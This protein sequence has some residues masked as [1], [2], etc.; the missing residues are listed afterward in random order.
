MNEQTNLLMRMENK[1]YPIPPSIHKNTQ[2]LTNHTKPYHS[3]ILKEMSSKKSQQNQYS[4]NPATFNNPPSHNIDSINNTQ[5]S[6]PK[7]EPDTI[8]NNNQDNN[9]TQ[10][11][12]YQIDLNTPQ[13]NEL[14]GF[15]QQHMGSPQIQP[16]TE[17]EI[18]SESERESPKIIQY[19]N[20]G[21]TFKDAFI[22]RGDSLMSQNSKYSLNTFSNS[23]AETLKQRSDGF[24]APNEFTLNGNFANQRSPSFQPDFS[25][26]G[27]SPE[28]HL[29]EFLTPES[30]LRRQA[31]GQ[32]SKQRGNVKGSSEFIKSDEFFIE[33]K[34]IEGK[35]SNFSEHQENSQSESGVDISLE[36]TTESLN[37]GLHM[38]PDLGGRTSHF[39]NPNL[40]E[41]SGRF[42]FGYLC[43]C[44]VL[45]LL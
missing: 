22:P 16:E 25:G 20:S 9:K 41:I 23:H 36:C 35:G 43:Y 39:K 13:F 37:F 33:N 24:N 14:M 15:K 8:T 28:V 31:Q 38:S 44:L 17:R 42:F 2:S 30:A 40:S 21:I 34:V 12:E 10:E 4:T 11:D 1:H 18:T 6:E 3:N 26:S 5:T 7:P 45:F 19:Q 27:M 29:K 32:F